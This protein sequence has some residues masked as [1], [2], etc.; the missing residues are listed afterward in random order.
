MKNIE[1]TSF[2]QNY[3]KN[4]IV[5]FP[6]T[7]V[8]YEFDLDALVHCIEIVP[9][10]IYKLDHNYIDWESNFTNEFISHFPDQNICFFS[11]DAFLGLNNVQFEL[12]GNKYIEPFTTLSNDLE[13]KLEVVK[14]NHINALQSISGITSS[15]VVVNHPI[16]SRVY[17]R[18]ENIS[19]PS[20]RDFSNNSNDVFISNN[21]PTAA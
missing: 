6:T 4:F 10:S 16:T 19:K 3:L 12:V 13:I 20:M 2:I 21:Y 14:I 11:D 7:R 15:C 5:L 18:S 8:R 1:A 17:Q 9:N